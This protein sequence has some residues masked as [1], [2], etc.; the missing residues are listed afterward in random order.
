MSATDA[1]RRLNKQ[2]PSQS[3]QAFYYTNKET[4]V[5]IIP[6]GALFCVGWAWGA[7]LNCTD[8]WAKYDT[9]ST[10]ITFVDNSNS[11]VSIDEIQWH[12]DWKDME[13][14]DRLTMIIQAAYGGTLYHGITGE[15]KT[16]VHGFFYSV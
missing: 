9:S 6:E 15:T 14:E 10:R 4:R 2:V 13:H 5:G 12:L 1:Q 3:T 11:S 8:V 7:L 16:Y